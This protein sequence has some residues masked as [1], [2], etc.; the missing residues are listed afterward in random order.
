MRK[1]SLTCMWVGYELPGAFAE[2]AAGEAEATG[3][4]VACVVAAAESNV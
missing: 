4:A 1:L 3:A 2:G